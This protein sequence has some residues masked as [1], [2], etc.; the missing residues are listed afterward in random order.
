EA[1][2]AD[3]QQD[4]ADRID[5]DSGDG[6]LTAQVRMAPAAMR[7]RLTPTPIEL[8]L[9]RCLGSTRERSMRLRLGSLVDPLGFARVRRGSVVQLLGLGAVAAAITTAVAVLIPW[10]PESASKESTRIHFVYWFTT[11]I[12]IAV[13]ATVAA[14]LAYSVIH[15][16][17]R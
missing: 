3:D 16:R 13:F 2:R 9:L 11:V 15:F 14:V 4:H 17:A 8:D 1:D 5:V 12:A 6:R 7:M 10:L